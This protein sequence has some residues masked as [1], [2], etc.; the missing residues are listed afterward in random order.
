MNLKFK[1]N[2]V[3]TGLE[4][5]TPTRQVD[6]LPIKLS[7][8]KFIKRWKMGLEPIT[9]Q[10]QYNVLPIKTIPFIS[11]TGFEPV[12]LQSQRNV[13]PIKTTDLRL[14]GF[15]PQPSQWKCDVLTN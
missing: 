1:Q 4:P 9:L 10:S 8:T 13:L 7:N 15:E 14:W 3:T 12:I 2:T 11:P 6:V 5:V